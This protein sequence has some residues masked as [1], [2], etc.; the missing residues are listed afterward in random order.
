MSEPALLWCWCH[1]TPTNKETK[2]PVPCLANRRVPRVS[3]LSQDAQA[4]E[5]SG[6]LGLDWTRTSG[7]RAK[8]AVSERLLDSNHHSSLKR[9]WRRCPRGGRRANTL[10]AASVARSRKRISKTTLESSAQK[11]AS[12]GCASQSGLSRKRELPR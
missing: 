2:D 1:F 8:V 6:R 10:S 4:G 5:E 9:R 12:P 11:W 7:T 3:D